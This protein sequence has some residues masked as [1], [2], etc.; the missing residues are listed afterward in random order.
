MIKKIIPNISSVSNATL[1][2]NSS[3]FPDSEYFERLFPDSEYF[4][5]VSLI[6]NNLIEFSI[7]DITLHMYIAHDGQ[8]NLEFELELLKNISDLNIPLSIT[9]Y[10]DD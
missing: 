2:Y 10:L 9:T 4:K 8:C 1:E 5:K 3:Y 7:Q 6:K